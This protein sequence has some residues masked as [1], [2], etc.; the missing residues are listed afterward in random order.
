MQCL[1][2][3]VAAGGQIYALIVLFVLFNKM[4]KYLVPTDADPGNSQECD[5]S[6]DLND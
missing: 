6:L 1:D 3:F 2:N 5:R 4:H